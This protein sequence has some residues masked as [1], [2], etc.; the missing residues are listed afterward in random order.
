MVRRPNR[1]R[2]STYCSRIAIASDQASL[3]YALPPKTATKAEAAVGSTGKP[4][5]IVRVKPLMRNMVPSVV[6]KAGTFS[7]VVTT[8]LTRPTSPAAS[9]NLIAAAARGFS[10]QGRCEPVAHPVDAHNLAGGPQTNGLT[11]LAPQETVSA[12]C[13]FCPRRPD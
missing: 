8:P 1:V 5:E 12:T 9:S 13:G 11:I 7:T 4:P 3:A 6:T 10:K 2:F